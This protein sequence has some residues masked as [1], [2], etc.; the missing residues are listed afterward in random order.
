MVHRRLAPILAA[1]AVLL[2]AGCRQAAEPSRNAAPMP[3]EPKVDGSIPLPQPKLDR[4]Q[5]IFAA[6]RAFTAAALSQQDREAQEALRGREFEIR[7]RFGC[8]GAAADPARNWTYDPKQQVLR[9]RIET[10]LA[11]EGVPASDLLL[12]GYEGVAGFVIE[13]P[14]LLSPG[15]PAPQSV[16]VSASGPTIAVAQLF[17]SDDSRVQ[18][19]EHSYEITRKIDDSAQPTQGLDLVL[20]GRLS[21]MSDG[22]VIHCAVTAGPPACIV[23]AKFD[24]VAIENPVDGSVL[25]D[26]SQW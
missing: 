20:R 7:L 21:Q 14:L 13:K 10:D 5:A 16:P 4:E 22:R 24:R 11:R 12:K 18:R 2:T 25:G 9:A 1:L 26:W 23:S 19:P 15:C 8:P 3:A 6:L 17:S